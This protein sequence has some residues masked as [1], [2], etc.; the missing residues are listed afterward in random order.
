[1][2]DA[3]DPQ[4][5]QAPPPVPGAIPQAAPGQIPSAQPPQQAGIP[6]YRDVEWALRI[7]K[8]EE[9]APDS[10]WLVEWRMPG[11]D[12]SGVT[13]R[14]ATT[15]LAAL[16]ECHVG[17]PLRQEVSAAHADHSAT[18]HYDVTLSDGGPRRR[19]GAERAG[20]PGGSFAVSLFLGKG[21]PPCKR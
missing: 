4:N 3:N 17:A 10:P 7:E 12:R 2:G 5:P 21:V 15:D 8:L 20:S 11:C 9:G 19:W 14:S 13:E 16:Q 6:A 1:M 18:H